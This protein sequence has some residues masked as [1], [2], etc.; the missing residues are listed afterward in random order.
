[1]TS[2]PMPD[3]RHIAAVERP[4]SRRHAA[5]VAL[6]Q[7]DYEN[8]GDTKVLDIHWTGADQ[9]HD[10]F[11]PK[12]QTRV[13]LELLPAGSTVY[14]ATREGITLYVKSEEGMWE[15]PLEGGRAVDAKPVSSL[16]LI[17]VHGS[18][19]VLWTPQ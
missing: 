5:A 13:E 15:R 2:A 18:V 19:R 10:A 16:Y 17:G 8:G 12:L 4:V 9:V 7:W 3:T 11:T 14:K 6:A 1:M